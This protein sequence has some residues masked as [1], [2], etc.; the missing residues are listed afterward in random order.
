VSIPAGL[1]FYAFTYVD[2]SKTGINEPFTSAG[3]YGFFGNGVTCMGVPT[4]FRATP[5]ATR[6]LTYSVCYRTQ[7]TATPVPNVTLSQ[8]TAEAAFPDRAH[9]GA[10]VFSSKMWIIGGFDSNY[11]IAQ[12]DAFENYKDVWFST[13]GSDWTAATRN[14][15]FGNRSRMGVLVYGGKMWMAGGT[16]TNTGSSTCSDVWS[17]TDGVDWSMT[18]GNAEFGKRAG[19]GMYDFNGKMWVVG[20]FSSGSSSQLSSV[21]SSTDGISWTQETAAA[22]FTPRTIFGSC[23]FNSKMWVICGNASIGGYSAEVWSSS[24]GIDW[25]MNTGA[26]ECGVRAA[27]GVAVFNGR[28]WLVGGYDN[29]STCD[30][31][32]SDGSPAIWSSADGVV[33]TAENLNALAVPA[34]RAKLLIYNSALWVFPG[35]DCYA[36]GMND[37]WRMN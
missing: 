17:S 1:D 2:V 13:N 35:G 26:A 29:S 30:G 5:A 22:D 14:A 24:N 20:G 28:I 11:D 33:W 3:V 27:P 6:V 21:Y 16:S 12:I 9:N 15:A 32:N 18:T 4:K 36:N 34:I 8:I 31:F 25:D 10:L 19:F 37:V 23:V 7:A